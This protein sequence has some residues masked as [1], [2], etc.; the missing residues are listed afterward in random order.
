MDILQILFF[1]TLSRSK[2]PFL[3][4]YEILSNIMQCVFPKFTLYIFFIKKS[5]TRL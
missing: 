3:I 4:N 2:H 5:W 1:K